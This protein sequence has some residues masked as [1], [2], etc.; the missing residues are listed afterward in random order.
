MTVLI[1]DLTRRYRISITKCS[2]FQSGFQ[3]QI[4]RGQ[5]RGVSRETTENRNLSFVTTSTKEL[6]LHQWT[7]RSSEIVLNTELESIWIL[8]CAQPQYEKWSRLVMKF[9]MICDKIEFSYFIY[10]QFWKSKG[11]G[12]IGSRAT[13]GPRAIGSPSLLYAL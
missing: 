11:P 4:T 12:Q 13:S 1:P 10:T 6:N 9:E 7:S 3:I 8:L 2:N 5:F